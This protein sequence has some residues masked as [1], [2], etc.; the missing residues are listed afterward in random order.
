MPE[1]SILE[2]YLD[3]TSP[4]FVD[5]LL[6][7]ITIDHWVLHTVEVRYILQFSF[8]SPSQPPSP[9]FFRDPSHERFLAQK[10]QSLLRAG[11][12]EE[13]LLCLR[14]RGFYSHYFRIPKANSDLRPILDL[15]NLNGFIKKLRFRMVSLASIIL[16][17]SRGLV[18][19]PQPKGRVFS[20]HNIPRTQEGVY[21]LW[22]TTAI[23]SS[24]CYPLACQHSEGI[25]K[26]HVSCGSLPERRGVHVYPYLDDWLIRGWFRDQVEAHVK[27]IWSTFQDLG[28]F[29][30]TQ[31]SIFAPAQ[32][33]PEPGLL[34]WRVAFE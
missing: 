26:W 30:N 16:S 5:W 23:I 21:D 28:L 17:G 6:S 15:Q 3:P 14:C 12:V 33:K 24:Q 25:H 31:K 10:M 20:N 9:S 8:S 4:L 18:Q 32:R 13:V 22:W 11:A 2:R 7:C 29:I 34:F 27:L 1:D 19:C